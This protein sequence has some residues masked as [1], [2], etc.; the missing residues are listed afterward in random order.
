MMITYRP[1]AVRDREFCVRVHH[2]SVRAYVEPIWGWNEA[3]ARA[4]Y[5]RHGFIVVETTAQK[6]RMWRR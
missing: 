6:V 4:F 3:R 5:E 1:L 2:L